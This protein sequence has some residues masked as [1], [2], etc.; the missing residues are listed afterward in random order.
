MAVMTETES[1]NQLR[2]R[3]VGERHGVVSVRDVRFEYLVN[4]AAEEYLRVVLVLSDPPG[5]R[6]GW[7]IDDIHELR[8][9]AQVELA[10]LRIAPPYFVAFSSTPA[11]GGGTTTTS[12]EVDK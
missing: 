4:E 10:D 3:M 11:S 2:W 6:V 8:R 1:L 9:K 12:M 5:N 7:P